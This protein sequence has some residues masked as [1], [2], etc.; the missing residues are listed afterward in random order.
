[1]A[2]QLNGRLE[3]SE[4][5]ATYLRIPTHVRSD[6]PILCTTC[7]NY[8]G[9]WYEVESSFMKQGGLNGV[10]DLHDGHIIKI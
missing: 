9:R 3:C 8:I 10:F 6:S 5:R 2:T 4:C 1:M 7:G